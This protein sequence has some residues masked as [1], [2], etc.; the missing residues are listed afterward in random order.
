MLRLALSAPSPYAGW[1]SRRTT[2][3]GL[4]I[5]ARVR[6]NPVAGMPV[7]LLHGLAVS[8]RYLMPTAHALADRHPVLVP[9]LPGFGFSD[10]PRRAYDVRQHAALVAAWLDTHGLAGICLLGHSFGAEIAAAVARARPELVAALVLACPTADPA[11]RT[12]LGL[13]GRGARDLPAEPFWQVPVIARDVWQARPWRVLAT[14]GHSAHN[15]IEDDLAWVSAPTL[16]LGGERDPVAPL[17]WRSR[18]A[19]LSGGVSVTVPGAPHNVLTTAG[20][21]AADAIAAHLSTVEVVPAVG[22]RRDDGGR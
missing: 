15:G 1:V 11:A 2:V 22:E 18:L 17:R 7:V 21:A 13:I 16:V 6:A 12:R 3:T 4:R 19:Q 5:H 8:H 20:P 10:R 14:V 9:D